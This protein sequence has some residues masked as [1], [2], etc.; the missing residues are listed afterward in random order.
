M[1]NRMSILEFETQESL[2]WKGHLHSVEVVVGIWEEKEVG[3]GTQKPLNTGQ[4]F[5]ES[6]IGTGQW[7]EQWKH[8]TERAQKNKA[9]IAYWVL[10]PNMFTWKAQEFELYPPM[11]IRV[12]KCLKEYAE[13]GFSLRCVFC[14]TRWWRRYELECLFKLCCCATIQRE[15]YLKYGNWYNI[16]FSPSASRK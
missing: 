13:V 8:F 15:W 1:L 12:K 5:H 11:Q 3:K 16:S 10:T 4:S 6:V 2:N 7:R 14:Q 9:A